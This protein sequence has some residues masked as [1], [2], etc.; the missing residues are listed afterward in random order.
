[1]TYRRIAPGPA[2]VRF[3]DHY[4]TLETDGPTDRPGPVQ[5]VVP[6][7]A[8]E[9]IIHLASPFELC[10]SD[11]WHAQPRCFFAGQ[12]T[13]PLLLRPAGPSRILAASFR[14]HGLA[15]LGIPARDL[16]GH[17]EPADHLFRDVQ[18]VR[19]LE[20]ALLRLAHRPADRIVELAIAE[21]SASRGMLDIASLARDFGLSTRHLER[22]FLECVG[23]AP[24]LYA[25]MRRFQSVWPAIEGGAPWAAAAIACGYYDQAHLIRDFR[26]FAGEPPA[27]L[28]A[29][30]DL[31]RHFLSHF[32]K[33][34]RPHLR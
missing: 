29:I 24:K 7:G 10:A 23:I 33:T 32:S 4:W 30:D 14:P 21:L 20:A 28:L 8:P 16:T 12:I 18:D 3:V 31:A 11:V 1:V 26:E 2:A 22:R 27:S 6:D 13:G 34:A 5:R 9:L 17:F 15:V 19:G 25:R